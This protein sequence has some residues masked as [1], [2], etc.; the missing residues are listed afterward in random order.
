MVGLPPQVPPRSYDVYENDLKQLAN[1]LKK[2]ESKHV[3][4]TGKLNR[5]TSALVFPG[6]T[7]RATL[8]TPAH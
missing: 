7:I 5:A 6:I 4:A 8:I 1:T 3:T 2:W